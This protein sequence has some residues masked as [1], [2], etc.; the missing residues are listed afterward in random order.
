MV[1]L[2]AAAAAGQKLATEAVLDNVPENTERTV[3]DTVPMTGTES[4]TGLEAEAASDTAPASDNKVLE[5]NSGVLW[6]HWSTPVHAC[7]MLL[8]QVKLSPADDVKIG[9]SALLDMP[10]TD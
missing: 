7:Q 4:G 2:P 8:L 3:T 5:Q 1:T 6:K 10:L 9:L